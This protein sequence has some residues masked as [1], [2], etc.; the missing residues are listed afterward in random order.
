MK[1]KDLIKVLEDCNPDY[2][3]K[4]GNG[5]LEDITVNETENTVNLY[6]ATED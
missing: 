4:V 1:V 5:F 2:D 3:I 6:Y